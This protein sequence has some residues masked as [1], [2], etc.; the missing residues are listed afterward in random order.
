ME[1]DNVEENAITLG[2][3]GRWEG[4][5]VIKNAG[6][7]P[8]VKFAYGLTYKECQNN[9]TQLK[10]ENGVIDKNLFS[11]QMLFKD[12]VEIWYRYTTY[13][14]RSTTATNYERML[15]NYI[16]P[17][18][19]LYPLNKITTGVLEHH[20]ATLLKNGRLRLRELYGSGLSVNMIITIHKVIVT[21]FNAAVERSFIEKNPATKAKIPRLRVASKKIYSYEELK[22]ILREAK[23]RNVY[24]LILFAL[25]TGMERG[26]ICALRWKDI[27]F[28]GRKVIITHTLRYIHR[29]YY[30][31]PVRKDCQRRQII[32][33]SQLIS[34][35]KKYKK[36]S[37]SIWVFPSVY[38]KVD[39]PRNPTVLT[40]LF[41]NIL[42]SSGVIEGSFQSLRDTSAVIYLD[43]GMDLRSLTSILGFEDVRTVKHAFVPYM[44]S[45][46]VVAAHRMEGAM[47]SI[48]SLYE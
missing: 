42:K 29:D 3:N 30:L 9:L 19:G 18:L 13:A 43:S 34:I 44:S 37:N 41:K 26:E 1:N 20:Y 2:K 33:S 6:Y 48:K 24:E 32:L 22:K 45:N 36:T 17:A 7:K 27:Q 28:K 31:E 14:R 4:R 40:T 35:M 23:R 38:G 47:S 25:C 46:K 16:L 10:I 12:W 21:I 8:V 5:V 11:Q 15:R 39:K